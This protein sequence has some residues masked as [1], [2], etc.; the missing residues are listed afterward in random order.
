MLRQSLKQRTRPYDG[1][2]SWT[3]TAHLELDFY[4]VPIHTC[5][6]ALLTCSESLVL[7]HFQVLL[8]NTFRVVMDAF[9]YGT[10]PWAWLSV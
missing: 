7:T 10:E 9:V 6:E 8:K 2:S 1:P 4:Y 5:D 3:P